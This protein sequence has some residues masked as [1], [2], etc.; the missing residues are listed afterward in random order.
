[1][2]TDYL[3]L[4]KKLIIVLLVFIRAENGTRDYPYHSI[5]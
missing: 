5:S 3:F 4:S 2:L 1:M